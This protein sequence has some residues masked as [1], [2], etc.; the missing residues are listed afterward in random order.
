MKAI[1]NANVVLAN[2]I[3]WDG[4]ILI[5]DGKIVS[6][7]SRRE[8]Y[9]PDDAEIIDAGGA[10]VGPGFVDIHVHGGNGFSTHKDV[11]KASEYFL[12]HGT[13]SILATTV[14]YMDKEQL[15]TAFRTVRKAMDSGNARTVK[16]IYAEGPFTNPKYGAHS[17]TNPWRFGVKP[18]DYE[19]MV[20]EAGD[21][22]KVWTVAPE[23][24]D[25]LPFLEYAKKI[26]PDVVFAVGHSE[27]TPIQIRAM[28][29]YRPELMTHAMCATGRQ[30]VSAGTRGYGPDEYCFKEPEMYAELISDSCGIHVHPEM[31]QLLLHNKGVEKVILITDST[32]HNNPVPEN[33]RHIQDLNFDP[34]GGI[35]G[36]KLTMDSAC[37]NI[38]THTNC[39]IAQAF[40]MASLNPARVLGMDDEIGSIETGKKADLVFVDDKFNVKK[41]MLEGELCDFGEEQK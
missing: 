19:D 10:Y 4:A 36:S 1:I 30:P 7:R 40:M 29:K 8:A 34:T 33:L 31:Q 39:G 9:I 5:S 13:T 23:R 15:I 22:I 21:C 28:G 35:A 26:N 2:G 3:L 25:L 38:M 37:R 14:Y 41:V 24:E 6:V 17:D 11:E 18:E 20:D 16:G 12:K 27:A 32:I